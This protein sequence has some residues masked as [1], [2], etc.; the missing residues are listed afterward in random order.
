MYDPFSY[1][2]RSV[3]LYVIMEIITAPNTKHKVSS[4]LSSEFKSKN[5]F[6]GNSDSCWNSDQGSPQFVIIDF[7]RNVHVRGLRIMFQGGFVG[8]D[9]AVDVGETLESLSTIITLE[10]IEDSNRTQSFLF[11]GCG[12]GGGSGR[13]LR[14]LFPSSTDFYGRVTIYSLEVLGSIL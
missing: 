9:C 12:G 1:V 11:D 10:V 2:L 13:Y 3:S 5:M 8:Q 7:A 14:L 6:D 4:Q